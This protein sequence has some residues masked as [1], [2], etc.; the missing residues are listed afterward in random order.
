MPEPTSRA[1]EESATMNQEEVTPKMLNE[2]ATSILVEN[3]STS[4]S[5]YYNGCAV[6]K[7]CFGSET[8]CITDGTCKLMFSYQYLSGTK[9][10]QMML[11]GREIGANEYISVGISSDDLM[12]SDLVFFC[13]NGATGINVAW[14]KGKDNIDGVTGVTVADAKVKTF[15][16]VTN[17]IFT[18]DE[19]LKPILPTS[20]GDSGQKFDLAA[21]KYYILMATG[22]ISDGILSYHSMK[23]QSSDPI[24]L[25]SASLVAGAQV[26]WIIQAHGCLMIFAWLTFASS[27]MLMARYYKQTWKSVKPLG[28][29]FWFRCHQGCMGIAILLTLVAFLIILAGRWVAPFEPKALAKNPHAVVGIVCIILAI[30]QPVMAYCRPHPGSSN[31]WIFNGAHW[32]LGNST[33]ILALA[34]IFLSID[35]PAAKL[36]VTLTHALIAYVVVHVFA[37]LVLTMQRFRVAARPDEVKVFNATNVDDDETG[38]Y[39]MLMR[40]SVAVVYVIFVWTF[41]IAFVVII[42]LS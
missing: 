18:V 34:A 32:F 11:H 22:P 8:N 42:F 29:D 40:K 12:G 26:G 21:S 13:S 6:T 38:D 28:K 2:A 3:A 41:A 35:L 1:L 36:P 25:K 37:H 15:D 17:C 31:R 30:I 20:S 33:F 23:T 27:G 4:S 39:G 24:N 16:S 9:S 5:E 19:T 7:G 14:N 10:F